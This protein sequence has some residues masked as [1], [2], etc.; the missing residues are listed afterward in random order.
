MFKQSWTET[1]KLEDPVCYRRFAFETPG[2]KDS[3]LNDYLVHATNPA[4]FE[5]LVNKG[6][7]FPNSMFKDE[8]ITTFLAAPCPNEVDRFNDSYIHFSD[9]RSIIPET[10]INLHTGVKDYNYFISSFD[11]NA[12][13]EILTVRFYYDKHVLAQQQ[14]FESADYDKKNPY[15]FKLKGGHNL[16]LGLEAVL[17][18]EELI[19]QIPNKIKEKIIVVPN[20]IHEYRHFVNTMNEEFMKFKSLD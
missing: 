20:L 10:S 13:F 7:I 17:V 2:N 11:D 15:L 18:P 19:V 8:K 1:R 9:P 3:I 12:P 14:G 6:F 4:N 5:L 16:Y